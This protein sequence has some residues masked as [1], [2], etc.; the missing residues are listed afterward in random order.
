MRFPHFTMRKWK[1]AKASK[2]KH[3]TN[4]IVRVILKN[5]I[6]S[7]A[8]KKRGEA[9]PSFEYQCPVLM[10]WRVR[11][12]SSSLVSVVYANDTA[13]SRREYFCSMRRHFIYYY[14]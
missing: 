11:S 2:H 3:T 8:C 13:Y 10:S 6:K 7:I 5:K 1:K 12:L 9:K 4:K 14:T